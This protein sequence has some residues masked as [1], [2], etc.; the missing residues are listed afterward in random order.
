[1][2]NGAQR[3]PSKKTA[4]KQFSLGREET[5]RQRLVIRCEV[6]TYQHANDHPW[7]D[8]SAKEQLLEDGK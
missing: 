6:F 7:M 3:M 2:P 8:V 4:Q 5:R 1:M